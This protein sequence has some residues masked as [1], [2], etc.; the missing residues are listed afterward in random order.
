[1]SMPGPGELEFPSESSE[2]ELDI[3]VG[4]PELFE[5]FVQ[6]YDMYSLLLNQRFLSSARI[7]VT[8]VTEFLVRP[9][10]LRLLLEIAFVVPCDDDYVRHFLFTECFA[11]NGST[12]DLESSRA[13]IED[14]QKPVLSQLDYYTKIPRQERFD[15]LDAAMDLLELCLRDERAIAI[16]KEDRLLQRYP[17]TVVSRRNC[18]PMVRSL[19][20]SSSTNKIPFQVCRAFSK[21][22]RSLC[23]QQ[24]ST[25][26]LLDILKESIPKTD[27]SEASD[28]WDYLTAW[29]SNADNPDIMASLISFV[30]DS[31]SLLSADVKQQMASLLTRLGFATSLCKLLVTSN[32]D[33][34]PAD[35][36]QMVSEVVIAILSVTTCDELR[37]EVIK[38]LPSLAENIFIVEHKGIDVWRMK[39]TGRTL[40]AGVRAIMY[41]TRLLYEDCYG[42]PP[43]V[44]SKELKQINYLRSIFQKILGVIKGVGHRLRTLIKDGMEIERQKGDGMP[45]EKVDSTD[46]PDPRNV[47][48]VDNLAMT[49]I[50]SL[51]DLQHGKSRSIVMDRDE[52]AIHLKGTIPSP[53]YSRPFQRRVELVSGLNRQMG[54]FSLAQ[55]AI[56]ETLARLL[57]LSADI[58]DFLCVSKSAGPFLSL[59]IG[60]CSMDSSFADP[61]S[62]GLLQTNFPYSAIAGVGGADAVDF[63]KTF[64][65]SN[66]GHYP[67]SPLQIAECY[68]KSGIPDAVL[69]TM[70][71]YPNCTICHFLG[72]RIII[73]MLE[74]NG[75]APQVVHSI[76][77]ETCLL[78]FLDLYA[79]QNMNDLAT[80]FTL[81]TTSIGAF[82]VSIASNIVRL[83]GN[84]PD[85]RWRNRKLDHLLTLKLSAAQ[86]ASALQQQ[87][88][89]LTLDEL[90]CSLRTSST[91]TN[92]I[93]HKISNS[94]RFRAFSEKVLRTSLWAHFTFCDSSDEFETMLHQMLH[95]SPCSEPP[96]SPIKS[97]MHENVHII[98]LDSGKKS[99]GM[100]IPI[101][102]QAPLL[103]RAQVSTI[104]KCNEEGCDSI[105]YSRHHISGSFL[106]SIDKR[107]S[108]M[109]LAGGRVSNGNRLT[110]MASYGFI[111]SDTH[112]AED[113]D[114][115]SSRSVPVGTQKIQRRPAQGI[116]ILRPHDYSRVGLKPMG[117]SSAQ[118]GC[119]LMSIRTLKNPMSSNS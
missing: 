58:R 10:T 46:S 52:D 60:T 67:L 47:S 104:R 87:H 84:V 27:P 39:Y 3:G 31:Q 95:L 102:P 70:I 66:G 41:M 4:G 37:L 107:K 8:Y 86:N 34:V 99:K 96:P 22:I 23:A 59:T 101:I 61:G 105:T 26:L 15:M 90:T 54:Q 82:L 63:K 43:S 79:G 93:L 48:A 94:V 57:L 115:T 114:G 21:L 72:T 12:V 49:V 7:Q 20:H 88:I 71:A 108:I 42:K 112:T 103:Q 19:G 55:Y 45:A 33:E 97:I 5:P 17:F 62:M 111:S 35:A 118:Q 76:I 38:C 28:S 98:R 83:A 91:A 81:S 36:G 75:H 64:C 18:F 69:L 16:I 74:Y 110:R 11:S 113:T 2:P 78:K 32:L 13:I 50:E 51:A 44:A 85:S 68:A 119:P 106:P 65:F 73:P 77:S 9:T 116:P 109:P 30:V 14:I 53:E 89:P 1:M 100:A 29:F 92:T 6:N 24:A 117:V 40:V 25:V 80:S 56:L